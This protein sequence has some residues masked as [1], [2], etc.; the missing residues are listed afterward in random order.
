MLTQATP[1]PIY[2]PPRIHIRMRI[3]TRI[4][5][6]LDHD[7]GQ[8]A[9]VRTHTHTHTHMRSLTRTSSDG[10]MMTTL[11]KQ[12]MYARSKLP[13]W[14]GPSLPTRPA[15][16]RIILTGRFWITTSWTTWADSGCVCV[17]VCVEDHPHRQ[18]L[19][20]HVVDHTE[21]MSQKGVSMCLCAYV[22]R[23]YLIVAS[24]HEG[25]VDAAEWL[26]PLSSL[27]ARARVCVRV[28]VRVSVSVSVSVSVYTY[29]RW[30]IQHVFLYELC[31]RARDLH[32]P[33]HPRTMAAAKVTAC[34]SAI[35]TS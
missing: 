4:Y 23:C 12:P 8:A 33:T 16:S 21:F 32:P 22:S 7:V 24:L 19:D 20:H 14:V 31:K 5:T 17:C 11:G 29:Q 10:A 27:F 15:R 26:Q 6:H 9:H 1:S 2:P 25:R 34:C 35:P 13:W 18:V 3:H 30:Y 28:R